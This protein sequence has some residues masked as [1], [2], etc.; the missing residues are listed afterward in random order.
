M[1]GARGD[2]SRNETIPQV[3]RPPGG[4]P[5]GTPEGPRRRPQRGPTGRAS[6]GMVRW[7]RPGHLKYEKAAPQYE[8]HEVSARVPRVTLHY[9]E[10]WLPGEHNT[11]VQGVRGHHKGSGCVDRYRSQGRGGMCGG[12]GGEEPLT[13]VHESSVRVVESGKKA[14]STLSKEMVSEPGFASKYSQ[15]VPLGQTSGL[16]PQRMP[17]S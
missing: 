14:S 15:E 13:S 3:A 10:H 7:R 8:R 9:S 4:D 12:K 17:V 6:P 11:R 16:A 5:G 2:R 1:N